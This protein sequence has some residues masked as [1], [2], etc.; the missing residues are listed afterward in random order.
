MPAKLKKSSKTSVSTVSLN[1]EKY[2]TETENRTFTCSDEQIN[3]EKDEVSSI[4]RLNSIVEKIGKQ[5]PRHADS[6]SCLV[7]QW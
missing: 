3:S 7:E 2:L 1:S 4:D 6:D 5:S